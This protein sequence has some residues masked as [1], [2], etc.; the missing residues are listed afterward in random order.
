MKRIH[1]F[2][3]TLAAITL[4]SSAIAT[5]AGPYV[6]IGAGESQVKTPDSYAFNV[7]ADP[8]GSTSRDRNGLGGR[9]FGGFNF[10]RWV[11]VEAGYAKYARSIY[12]GRASGA[13]S[14][15][16][17]YIHAYDIVAKGYIPWGTSGFNLY[18]LAGMARVVQ[19]ENYVNNG[20][21]TTGNIL[22]PPNSPYH[23]YRN[24]PLYGLG[25]NYNFKQHL[26]INVEA[27]QIKN[28]QSFPN[29]YNP[30]P[31]INFYSFNIAY[32]FC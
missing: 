29:S 7:S 9:V 16:R 28:E 32:N 13:Y 17:Y 8:N 22:M 10:N 24:R 21:P 11:G 2:A 15:L 5:T 25:I 12:V 4:S 27:T 1:L 3:Y 19:T 6:G 26:T 20:V 14:S 31:N 18:A 30:T 23:V